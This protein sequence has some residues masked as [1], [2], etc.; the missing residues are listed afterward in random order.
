[1]DHIW[2]G[3]RRLDTVKNLEEIALM[4]RVVLAL[5]FVLPVQFVRGGDWPQW[6]GPNRDNVWR[7]TGLVQKFPPGGPKVVWRT[8]VRGGYAGPA[9]A[10]GKVFVTD[11]VTGDDAKIPN[12]ER[13]ELTGIERVLCIDEATGNVL[14]KHEYP[15]KYTISYPAGPRTT[16][17]IDGGRVYTQ[18]AEGNVFCLDIDSGSVIWAKDLRKEYDTKTALWGYAS[19]PLIDGRKLILLAGGEGS[20]CVALDKGTGDEIWRTGT[21]TEQ[22]YSP[23]LL[24]EQAGVRQLILTKPDGV[25]S[26]DPETGTEFWSA[27][28]QAD[29]GAIIM[30]PVKIGDYLY[31]GGFNNRNLLLKL[32]TDKPGAEVVWQDKARHGISPINVQPFLLDGLLYGVDASGEL[33][34]IEFPSGKIKWSTTQPLGKRKVNSGTVFLVKQADADRFWMFAESGDLIIGTLSV[35]GFTEIDRTHVLDPTNVAFGRDVLWCPPAFA[36]RRMYVRN[37]RELICVDLAR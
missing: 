11:Y 24:I 31:V 18:G 7:D 13:S 8:P 20:H 23:P 16:P 28:Y 34:A 29:N 1:M 27:P 35:E 26:V 17:I 12:F 19:Q 10:A 30:T 9:V 33:R 4:R 15:V 3:W 32:A 36:N 14:W 25:Y 5:L 21:A 2:R 37:D 6:M 22:G